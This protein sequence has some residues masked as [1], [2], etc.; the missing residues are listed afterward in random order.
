MGKFGRGDYGSK[1]IDLSKIKARQLFLEALDEFYPEIGDYLIEK[2][3]TEFIGLA[4]SVP[5][6]WEKGYIDSGH[7][8]PDRRKDN[9]I[10]HYYFGKL[11]T[12]RDWRSKFNINQK[13]IIKPLIIKLDMCYQFY[14]ANLPDKEMKELIQDVGFFSNNVMGLLDYDYGEERK[15]EAATRKIGKLRGYIPTSESKDDYKL[16]IEIFLNNI[17]QYFEKVDKYMEKEGYEEIDKKYTFRQTKADPLDH[18]RWFIEKKFFE[19]DD[20]KIIR[21]HNRRYIHDEDKQI[22]SNYNLTNTLQK[23]ALRLEWE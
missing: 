11:S 22:K 8:D 15:I 2:V 6:V 14:K 20:A 19:F 1:S 3:Y 10:I 5:G 13:W 23:V 9:E 12:L 17:D 7:Y 21:L 18:M 4:A 16:R